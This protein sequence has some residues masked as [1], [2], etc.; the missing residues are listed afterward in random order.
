MR[1][2]NT[3]TSRATAPQTINATFIVRSNKWSPKIDLDPPRSIIDIVK[4]IVAIINYAS[5]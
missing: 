4:T 3:C 1:I 2:W 5:R